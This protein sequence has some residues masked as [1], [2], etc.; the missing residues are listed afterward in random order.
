MQFINNEHLVPQRHCVK[1]KFN[2]VMNNYI[3]L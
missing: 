2:E 1:L 3:S